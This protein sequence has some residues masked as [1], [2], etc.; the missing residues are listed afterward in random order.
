[1]T[2]DTISPSITK[3]TSVKKNGSYTV[4]EVIPIVI[5]FSEPIKESNLST[6]YLSVGSGSGG[7][8][9]I[10]T[11]Y[12][13]IDAETKTKMTFNYTIAAGENFAPL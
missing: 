5:E 12:G 13:G 6:P 1:M 2:I 4:G 10:G 11:T 7:G 9:L 3:V 8:V